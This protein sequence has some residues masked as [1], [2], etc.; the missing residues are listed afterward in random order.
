MIF[1]ALDVVPVQTCTDKEP[2]PLGIN[3]SV[4]TSNGLD[5]RDSKG[6]RGEEEKTEERSH[7]STSCRVT[8]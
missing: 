2:D 4:N 7:L 1:I 6:D 3:C 8:G 5:K